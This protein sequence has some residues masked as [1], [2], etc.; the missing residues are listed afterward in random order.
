MH[1]LADAVE[2]LN[3]PRPVALSPPERAGD[4]APAGR[5]RRF[6]RRARAGCSRG[7][8]WR[9]PRP[10]ATTSLLT[11]PP[12]SGK[13]MM[14]RRV[15]GILPPLTFDEAL[16]VTS[17][18]SV[19]GLL[20][21]GH[22]PGTARGRFARRTTPSR[23]WRSPAAAASRGPARSASRITACCFS[24]RCRSS[25]AARSK[26]CA[27]RS[28]TACVR[29]ARAQRTAVFPARFV[30]IGAMNPC[31]CG[32]LG[33]PRRPCRCTPMQIDRYAGRLSGPL[34]DRIDLTVDV[35][36][37]WPADDSDVHGKGEAHGG[38]PRARR[39]GARQAERARGRV[40]VA[41][42]ARLAP[43]A[44][45]QACSLDTAGERLLR[46]AA[47]RLGLTARAFDRTPPRRADDR[48]PRRRG[49]RRVPTTSPRRCSSEGLGIRQFGNLRDCIDR[50]NRTNHRITN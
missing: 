32:Y 5:P 37:R 1:S 8:R 26:C 24:T 14:A 12:G 41:L 31:P 19:A 30:L 10:A 3:D 4:H 22:G 43:R 21:A 15:A 20:G 48:G 17:I 23:T 49:P 50:R 42:N 36:A 13:T 44:L 9:S 29:I 18:H 35:V 40:G 45:R 47:E 2:A 11:G 38:H 34:R 39:S 6:R 33:D 7:A 46:R 28:K 16:E 25:A 27:S